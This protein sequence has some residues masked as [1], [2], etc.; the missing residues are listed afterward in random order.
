MKRDAENSDKRWREKREECWVWLTRIWLSTREEAYQSN[1]N[2][3]I[4][5]K[6][7]SFFVCFD[8]AYGFFGWFWI[9]RQ[10]EGCQKK[11]LDS[12]RPSL[13]R[14][15]KDWIFQFLLVIWKKK[16]W[17]CFE[18]ADLRMKSNCV[19]RRR[20]SWSNQFQVETIWLTVYSWKMKK[21][22]HW[23]IRCQCPRTQASLKKLI[24]W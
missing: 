12:L 16:I 1:K 13:T 20:R 14:S 9:S 10:E 18:S 5:Q 23:T 6:L 7:V 19:Q 11:K 4:S 2:L 17:D 24:Q 15:N 22:L 21:K 3:Q 8:C